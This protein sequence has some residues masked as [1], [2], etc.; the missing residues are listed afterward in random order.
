MLVTAG[1]PCGTP[2]ETAFIA[3]EITALAREFRRV[4]ILPSSKPSPGA[5]AA[6]LPANVEVDLRFAEMME[7]RAARLRF[8]MHPLLAGA[9][10]DALLHGYSPVSAA[11][12]SAAA[13]AWRREMMQALDNG[14]VDPR[15]TLFYTFWLDYATAGLALLS[16][17]R[18][19]DI[20]SRVHG[21]ELRDLRS[22]MLRRLTA[23]SVRAIYAASRS[24]LRFLHDLYPAEKE[25]I[26]L[27]HMG[28]ADPLPFTAG[29]ACDPDGG[30]A[31][32]SV[33]RVIPLKRVDMVLDMA[34]SLA[35]FLPDT[36]VSWTHIGGGSAMAE[37]TASVAGPL[38]PNLKVELAGETPNDEIHRIMSSRH[39]D[40]N[41]LLS[42]TEGGVPVSLCEGASYGI[43]AIATDVG[44]ISELVDDSTGVLVDAN[45]DPAAVAA[46]IA[47]ISEAD[48]RRKGEAI[49][50]RWQERFAAGRLRGEFARNLAEGRWKW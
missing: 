29:A 30:I 13:L 49:R 34:R 39:F 38:E 10:V 40:W 1:Y 32:L 42:T 47:A 31:L 26:M 15:T 16:H 8:A 19:I 9:A 4:I 45:P 17:D 33:A 6:P 23:G 50:S 44:G 24:A 3:P 14:F 41:I 5:H 11:T 25:R 20:V 43:P 7:R 36:P 2:T 37:L 22:P 35:R 18:P 46:R 28:S 27:R 12:F 21:Y 48:R